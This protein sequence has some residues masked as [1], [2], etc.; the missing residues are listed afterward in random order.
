LKIFTRNCRRL[1][2]ADK[3]QASDFMEGSLTLPH[4][5]MFYGRGTA[6]P[7][8]ARPIRFR[9]FSSI[10][11]RSHGSMRTGSEKTIPTRWD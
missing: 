1:S 7:M 9:F 10:C 6:A 8:S 4:A 3:K 11:E 5:A 2:F